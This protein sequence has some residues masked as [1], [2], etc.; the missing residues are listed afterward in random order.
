MKFMTIAKWEFTHRVKSKW[1]IFSLIF[2]LIIIG[3]SVLPT[4]LMT[5]ETGGKTFAVIDSTGW[6]DEQIIASFSEQYQTEEGEPRYDWI[7]LQVQTIDNPTAAAD[8]MLAQD[9]IQGYV[10]IPADVRESRQVKFFA[11]SV[12]NFQDQERITSTVSTLVSRREM[13]ENNLDADL[14]QDLTRDVDLMTYEIR[15]GEAREGNELMAFAQPYFFVFLLMISI[16]MSSQILMRSVL[17]ERQN[18]LV[19]LLVS[20]VTT[21]NLM[22]GK[23]LGIGAMGLL[24]VIIYIVLA[25]TFAGR[26]DLELITTTGLV[27][28]FLFFIPG[29]LLYSS[30]YASVGSLFTS[31]QDAQQAMGVLSMIIVL[32]IIFLP[33]AITNPDTVWVQILSYVPPITPF[34]MIMRI[35]LGVLPI[36]EYILS[37]GILI[38]FTYLTMR[39]AGKVFNTAILMYGKRPTL[40]EIIRWIRA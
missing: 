20:S 39:I 14:I 18:R 6:L 22:S 19:E 26:F 29:Y 27:G 15:Q 36:W 34:F 7:P 10:V 23:I 30:F 1:F 37:F 8:S 24:Q 32:P 5:S 13:E 9:I 17:E 2:P 35:N 4:L 33:L 16:L 28:F 25:Q 31:E 11:E 21:N 3:F 12:T 38:G 40:P